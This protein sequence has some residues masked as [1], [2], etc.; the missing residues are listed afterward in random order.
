[1]NGITSFTAAVWE[2][3][4]GCIKHAAKHYI[5]TNYDRLDF[6]TYRV[7]KPDD[8][9][10]TDISLKRIYPYDAPENIIEFDAIVVAQ[11]DV[12]RFTY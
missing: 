9:V 11:F 4:G 10:L 1:M 3:Y 12:Y 5:E 7:P 6:S 8:T 2:K